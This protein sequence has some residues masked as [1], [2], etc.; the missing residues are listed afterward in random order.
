MFGSFPAQ[1]TNRMTS[2]PVQGAGAVCLL[3][4]LSLTLYPYKQIFQ[5]AASIDLAK[6]L[7]FDSELKPNILDGCRHVY[8][9][10]GTNQ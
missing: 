3:V 4:V 9:D 5:P 7:D 2:R 10:M 8:L 6:L 1:M